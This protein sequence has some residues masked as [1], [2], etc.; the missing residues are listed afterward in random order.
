MWQLHRNKYQFAKNITPVPKQPIA[1]PKVIVAKAIVA[2]ARHPA[3]RA[4]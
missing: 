4:V 3:N 1:W 2:R